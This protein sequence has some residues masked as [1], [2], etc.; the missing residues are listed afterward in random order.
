MRAHP[1]V[2]ERPSGSE[3]AVGT[4]KH[5]GDVTEER[6]ADRLAPSR[7]ANDPL[8]G[9]FAYNDSEPIEAWVPERVWQRLCSLGFAYELHYLSLS[10]GA[11]DPTAWN[12]RQAHALLEELAFVGGVINDRLLNEH[13][14]A[15]S[16]VVAVG[17]RGGQ[18]PAL[19]IEGQ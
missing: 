8:V 14:E 19:R 5:N 18:D 6:Y 11:R 3:C 7:Y 4:T 9:V 1:R 12:T 13:L 10:P 2:I 15:V 17:A 16:R